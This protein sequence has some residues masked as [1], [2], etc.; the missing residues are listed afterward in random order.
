MFVSGAS[1]HTKNHT[2]AIFNIVR[3]LHTCSA[4]I[5]LHKSVVPLPLC[6][7]FRH[8]YKQLPEGLHLGIYVVCKA[9]CKCLDKC[10]LFGE[11]NS[12]SPW[13]ASIQCFSSFASTTGKPSMLLIASPT[14]SAPIMICPRSWPASV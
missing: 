7:V 11:P 2:I 5:C 12:S 14:H 9:K 1:F 3:F 13:W 6:I 4:E 10:R 8:I